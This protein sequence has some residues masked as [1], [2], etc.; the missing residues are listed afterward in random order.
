MLN[1]IKSILMNTLL[2]CIQLTF[3][4]YLFKFKEIEIQI[5]KNA[6]SVDEIMARLRKMKRLKRASVF[7]FYCMK[8]IYILCFAIANI[9]VIYHKDCQLNSLQIQLIMKT[10][11][12]SL[13]FIFS[14]VSIIVIFYFF[15]V[16]LRFIGYF[17]GIT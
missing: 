9:I 14:I 2:Q 6:L 10:V 13:N 16:A 3:L 4:L 11:L 12:S 15:Q 17:N 7:S 1:N 5:D 8:I